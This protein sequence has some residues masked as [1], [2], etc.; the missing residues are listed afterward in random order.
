MNDNKNTKESLIIV[1]FSYLILGHYDSTI[2]TVSL[3]SILFLSNSRNSFQDS[4]VD[5]EKSLNEVRLLFC[6]PK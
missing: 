5:M 4:E 1:E 3:V 6:S 2:S